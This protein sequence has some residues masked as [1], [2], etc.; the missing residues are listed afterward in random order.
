MSL[1]ALK[2]SLPNLHSAT[3]SEVEIF[4]PEEKKTDTFNEQLTEAETRT[5]N[6][7]KDHLLNANTLE[8]LAHVESVLNESGYGSEFDDLVAFRRA[9]IEATIT[10]F[11]NYLFH[12]HSVGKI[13]SGVPKTLTDRQQKMFEDYTARKNGEGRALTDKQLADWGDLYNKKHAKCQLTDGAKKELE[14]LF[15]RETTGR[16]N[17]IQAKQLDKG[18]ICEDETI[19]LYED[20]VGG[21][22]VKNKERKTNDFFNGEAD[23]IQGKIRDVKTSWEFESFPANDTEIPSALYE[24][25]LD[26]YMD[27]WK[28]KESELIY[29]LVDTPFNLINDELRRLDWKLDVL[30]HE[31]NVRESQIDTVVELILNHIYTRRGLVNFCDQNENIKLDWFTGKFKEIPKAKRLKIYTHNY[32][33][34][35]NSQLKEMIGLARTYLNSLI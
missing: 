13:M 33:A 31:G 12:P 2:N 10:N 14:R 1:E 8:D 6:R 23:N 30:D 35:R 16:S 11:D 25:Q 15:W 32:C 19:E 21:V 28:L 17:K 4:T 18:I 34:T 29:G 24:W 7:I 22:F 5:K 20:V 26:A 27:L 9:E 3:V